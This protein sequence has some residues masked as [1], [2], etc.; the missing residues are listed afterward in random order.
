MRSPI[1]DTLDEARAELERASGHSAEQ[2]RRWE[3]WLAD[4]I[5]LPSTYGREH[6]IVDYVS[7]KLSELRVRAH[8]VAHDPGR[9]S[10]VC[11]IKGTGG[12]RSLVLNA[13]LDV[14]PA[15]DET[16][17]THPPFSGYID[18]SQRLIFGRGALDDKA[19]VAI[20]LALIEIFRDH[21]PAGDLTFHFVL[22][23]ETT[24]NGSLL[25]LE[26]GW[27]GDAALIIDGTRLDRAISQHAGQL[28]FSVAVHGKPA[29]ISV[30]HLGV[31]AAEMLAELLL[32]LRTHVRDLNAT[33]KE[34]WTRFPSP[35]QL[36]VQR[37][38]SE[39][40]LRTVPVRADAVAYATFPPPES[41]QSMRGRLEECARHFVAEKRGACEV[42]LAWDGF[43]TEPA[44]S[45]EDELAEALQATAH[46][47]KIPPIDVGPST[48][49]SDMRHFVARGIPCLLYGPGTGYNPHRADESYSLDDL[50]RMVSLYT[51]FVKR[52]CRA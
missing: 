50:P 7:A 40:E 14:V 5:R 8:G 42:T 23:D 48:G 3:G 35:F 43:A 26:D 37:L 32:V 13:H 27:T 22:D 12:G 11:R 25:C 33:R 51:A 39:G 1:R 16:A 29:S 15:G 52:W 20:L 46:E 36:V 38:S 24:G 4:M 31:N 28:Q 41:L 10:L 34:P 18:T 19:G 21:P 17:W 44:A 6:A 9:R 47:L 45:P 2:L 49:T 30:P